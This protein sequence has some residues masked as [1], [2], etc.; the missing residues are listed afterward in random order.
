MFYSA[1]PL[2]DKNDFISINI[3][4]G[5]YALESLND[6][7]RRNNIA[8]GHFTEVDYPFTINPILQL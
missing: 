7:I 4:P 2:N 1:K 3:P 5:A 6:E 8:E